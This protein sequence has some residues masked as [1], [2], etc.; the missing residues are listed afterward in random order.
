MRIVPV[1]DVKGGV[2]VHGVAGDRA[3]YGP[4]RSVLANDPRPATVARAFA[5][6]GAFQDVYV[7]DLDAIDGAPP[8]WESLRQIARS[9]LRIWL[10]AG[11]D[12]VARLR[13]VTHFDE[14]AAA[15]AAIILGSESLRDLE[16]LREASVALGPS[17]CI[18]SLDLR[19]TQPLTSCDSWRGLPSAEIAAA[20]FD[21]G[22]RRMILLDLATV[23]TSRGPQSLELARRLGAEHPDLELIGGGG[24]RGLDD[25]RSLA[26]AGF[27]AALVAT[28]LHTGA[29]LPSDAF[30]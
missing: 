14:C 30:P 29:I 18:F 28:A 24:V 6:T 25:L 2:V 1:I 4:I 22:V 3:N 8:D 10:D 20:A 16:T 19:D 27:S 9:G 11:V 15:L 21:R 7:A 23:G 13:E 17:R 12:S 5:E 26:A